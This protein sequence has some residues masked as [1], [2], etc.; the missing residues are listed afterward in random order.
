MKNI[1]VLGAG[2]Q[3]V[4]VALALRKH[5]YK[6]TLIDQANGCIERTSLVNEGKIHLGHIYANDRSG[7]TSH[8]MLQSAL[9]FAPLLEQW[10][11]LDI[12]WQK[13]VSNPFLYVV[14]KSSLLLPE[15]LYAHY[16]QL[17]QHYQLL[18]DQDGLHYLGEKPSHLWKTVQLPNQISR[19]FAVSAVSTPERAV[20][21]E[22][23]RQ[24]LKR[25]IDETDSIETLYNHRVD[26]VTRTATGFM[27]EGTGPEEFWQ[28]Q[29]D[30]V[31]NCLWDGRLKI[32][33]QMG[34]APKRRWVYRLKYR[35]LA[36]LPE[37]LDHLPAITFVLGR[38][39]D[40][41]TSPVSRTVYLSWYP[42]CLQGWCS[43]ISP[44]RDWASL[45]TGSLDLKERDRIIASTLAAFDKIIPGLGA[46]QVDQVRA[47]TIFSWGT[48]D[49]DD[50]QSGLHE[51]HNIG[52]RSY[53]GYFSID[54]GKYTC[55]PFFANQLLA[56]I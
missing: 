6:V 17:D 54:T 47:G 37:H 2:I 49:I 21:R 56:K 30:I 3:G 39:G 42:S 8:L 7:K 45:H 12:D 28:R 15:Q 48:T 14:A 11:E 50:L 19:D 9:Q 52:V 4:C 40:V 34:I 53:D 55:A 46:S 51:R 32:D 29:A 1:V 33:Q 38:F 36:T 13:I 41:V 20:D 43:E 5:Q 18:I 35:M 23:I 10:T 44:P 26:S 22:R 16:Q 31:V 25:F 27:V 24:L